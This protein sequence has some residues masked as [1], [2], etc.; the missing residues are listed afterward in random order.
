MDLLFKY[1]QEKID[2]YNSKSTCDLKLFYD[3]VNIIYDSLFDFEYQRYG[4]K[5][6]VMFHHN[7]SLNIASGDV[8]VTYKIINDNLTKE[9]LFNNK[10][11]MKKNDFSLLLDLT[12]NGFIRGE[13]RISYWGVKYNRAQDSI[14]KL[15]VDI[16]SPKFTST[17]LKDKCYDKPVINRMYDMVVDY[18]LDCKKIKPH[19]GI[20]DDIQNEYPKKKWLE[21]NDYKFLPAVLDSYGIKSKY[22]I[23]ELNVY[24]GKPIHISSLNYIC[25]LFGDNYLDYIKQIPW[26]NH[27]FDMPPNRKMHQLKNE[28][29]KSCLVKSINNWETDTLKSDTLIYSLNRLFTIR[30]LLESKKI[31]LKFKAKN[32]N[33]FENHMDTW[34]GIKLHFT[35]GYK[36]KYS[37]EQSVVNDIERDIVIDGQTY[38]PNILLTEE[39]YRVEG[40]T[41]KNCMSKQFPHGSIYIFISLHHGRKKI[42]LQY[43]KGN[44]IQS[45]GKANTTVPE[46]YNEAIDVLTERMRKH[47]HVE[48]KREKYDFLTH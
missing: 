22:L 38:K 40:Y 6:K 29:E 5:K 9:K 18:H 7:L 37:I 3:N 23:G 19:D 1:N 31:D 13:K 45:Y 12:E 4:N 16:L 27:C 14:C 17:F 10:T 28:S 24:E 26:K 35:R 44:L 2:K 15:L 11:K 33:E 48:W 46:L 41:M 42:N 20:Y 8:T 43:R 21:K 32:D 30:D 34:L 36:L 47:S 25:K 39:D